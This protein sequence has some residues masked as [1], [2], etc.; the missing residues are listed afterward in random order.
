MTGHCE[1]VFNTF[2]RLFTLDA[3]Y[4]FFRSILSCNDELFYFLICFC[5]VFLRMLKKPS[6][7]TFSTLYIYKHIK[8]FYNW[9]G[10]CS[11]YKFSCSQLFGVLCLFLITRL[12]IFRNIGFTR[13]GYRGN[14][15]RPCIFRRTQRWYRLVF[16]R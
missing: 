14:R 16:I 9:E 8:H 2:I 4:G 11:R 1:F 5:N 15:R 6:E 3:N 13:I 10:V 12:W 7:H